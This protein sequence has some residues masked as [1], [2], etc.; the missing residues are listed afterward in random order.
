MVVRSPSTIL[1]VED[2][3]GIAELEKGRLEDVGYR[4][5]LAGN[6][7]DAIAAL[8]ATPVDLILLDYRLPGGVD[9]LD[10][11]TQVRTAGFDLPV[12]LVTGFSNEATVIRALRAGVRDFVT[13]SVEYLDYLPDAVDR[14]LRQ[15]RTE[16]RLAES[17]ARLASIIS[18]AKD[19]ILVSGSDHRITLFNAAAEHMFRCSAAE[20]IG[21]AVTRFIPPDFAGDDVQGAGDSA[22]FTFRLRTGTHGVRADGEVFPLEASVSQAHEGGRKF[23][24]IVVRD[25]T[26]RTRAEARIREQAALLDQARDAILV[27]D[28]D[29]NVLYW[30]RGAEYLYGWTVAE[31]LGR[32]V[33]EMFSDAPS[34]E[35]VAHRA[36][37]ETGEWTGEI[38]QV[39]KDGRALVIES[40]RTL[41]RDAA[42]RPTSILIINTDN[43]EK[44][45]L[46][47]QLQHTQRLEAIGVLASGVAHDFNN[48]LT[49]ISGY[50][51]M[52]LAQTRPDTP[53]Y[54]MLREIA[55]AGDSATALTQQLLA[56]GR[57]QI[58]SPRVLNLNGLVAETE[59]MLRRL[60]GAD[61]EL[62]TV[63]EPSLGSVMAD[64]GQIDQVLI[65]LVVN[66]RDAM[67][68]GGG[69]TLATRN[70][71]VDP[72]YARQHVGV[73]AGSYVVLAV[74]DTGCG[75]DEATQARIL[76]P[77]FT[78]KEV[79]K[80]TGLGLAMVHGIVTQS[81]GFI[82][83]ESAPGRGTRFQIYLPRV[84]G[85]AAEGGAH[86]AAK[87][88]GGSETVLLVEDETRVRE[89]GHLALRSVGYNVLE[90]PDGEQALR[91]VA[92]H[93]GPIHLLVTDV[94]MPRMSGRVL[95][96][97]LTLARP[98]VKVLYISGY[99]DEALAR[100]GVPTPGTAFLQ[101]PFTPGSLA[102]TVR[103]LLGR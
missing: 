103:D 66:A 28:L 43:T 54:P 19:A 72:E 73:T 24:T 20:A 75:M 31:A 52:L 45:K 25:I 77:F 63:L 60:I 10:F 21:Q 16:S 80:G 38:Q 55:K 14:V 15:V 83:V 50:S 9:G 6:A 79:G 88:Q 82:E 13:K 12:I 53:A 68:T 46:E 5:I 7:T 65:N 42:G 36:V 3:P 58:L 89:L 74:T 1:I 70:T 35:R 27:R 95:A 98:N 71:A 49:V 86:P 44:K 67:P 94:V 76:E 4:I 18:S 51:E 29:D 101:K 26:E 69:V 17:E 92:R 47:T 39:A 40:R 84:D 81:G 2:D 34:L 102:R 96:D 64:A 99:T 33:G 62:T 100:H 23:Y 32:S 97:Q 91:L 57:K 59:K 8:R 37:L 61:V 22:R 93:P 41:L 78:T 85:T 30:N 87:A 90:A 11:F 48:L 56:F